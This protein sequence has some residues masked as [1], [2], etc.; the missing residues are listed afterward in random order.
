LAILI[1]SAIKKSKRDGFRGNLA[2]EREIKSSI[3]NTLKD[4]SKESDNINLGDPPVRYGIVETVERIFKIII[5]QKE[6]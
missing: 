3:Y 5:E 4:Y 2:K 6:Y 1:D